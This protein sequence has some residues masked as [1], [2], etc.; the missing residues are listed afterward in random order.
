MSVKNPRGRTY[1]FLCAEPPRNFVRQGPALH[2]VGRSADA[3][4]QAAAPDEERGARTRKTRAQ[5]ARPRE[6]RSMPRCERCLEDARE[7]RRK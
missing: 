6:T 4:P 7:V 3:P 2:P 1:Q 5:G